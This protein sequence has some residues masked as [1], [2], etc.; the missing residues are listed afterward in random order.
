MES[1]KQLD[2]NAE[3]TLGIDIAATV[4]AIKKDNALG[5]GY[6]VAYEHKAE[7]DTFLKIFGMTETDEEIYYK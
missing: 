5:I 6:E 7:I 3:T 4:T 2:P 1:A